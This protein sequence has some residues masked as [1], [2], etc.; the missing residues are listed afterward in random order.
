MILPK[1]QIAASKAYFQAFAILNLDNWQDFFQWL[2]LLTTL[3][4]MQAPFTRFPSWIVAI[5]HGFPIRRFRNSWH[6]LCVT[7]GVGLQKRGGC[8]KIQYKRYKRATQTHCAT[9]K[10]F[11]L[12][13]YE[14][15]TFML[16][17]FLYLIVFPFVKT[18]FPPLPPYN[19]WAV[20]SKMAIG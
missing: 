13:W 14:I 17:I 15:I 20:G 7:L 2:N 5:I 4:K 9:Q 1:G 6:L 19:Y 8:T 12:S 10:H 3:R 16:T 18:L 11:S